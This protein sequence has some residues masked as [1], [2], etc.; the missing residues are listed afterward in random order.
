MSMRLANSGA[1]RSRSG[2]PGNN[3]AGEK[4]RFLKGGVGQKIV[5][6]TSALAV[7]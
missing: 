6:K 7:N 4:Q 1:F 5:G 2:N 3:Q